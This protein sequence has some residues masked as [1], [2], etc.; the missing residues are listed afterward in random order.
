MR[1]SSLPE[2]SASAP[3][4]RGSFRLADGGPLQGQATLKPDDRGPPRG[5]RRPRPVDPGAIVAVVEAE[6]DFARQHLLIVRDQNFGDEA[7]TLVLTGVTSPR[8]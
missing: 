7:E 6:Q 1:A 3:T 4:L 2:R 8:T 5:K